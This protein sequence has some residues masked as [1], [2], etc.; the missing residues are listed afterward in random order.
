[1]FYG[2][3]ITNRL[4]NDLNDL[5]VPAAFIDMTKHK[6]LFGNSTDK[7]N[8]KENFLVLYTKFYIW[9]ERCA[10]R[11]IN[12]NGLKK[13]LS[14]QIK[15]MYVKAKI[16]GKFFEFQELWDTLL[17]TFGINFTDAE[18]NSLNSHII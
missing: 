9:R 11:I 10:G 8:T 5:L 15:D 16:K 12:F 6:I 14:I 13:Y 1:M 7:I 17:L 2:C 18:K 3:Q 4:W